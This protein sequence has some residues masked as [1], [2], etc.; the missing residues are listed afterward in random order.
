V[1]RE[2]GILLVAHGNLAESF[3]MSMEMLMGPIQGLETAALMLGEGREQLLETMLQKLEALAGYESVL[4]VADLVGWTPSNTAAEL[5]AGR[6]DLQLIA[7]ANLALLCEIAGGSVLN[8]EVIDA[9]L[10]LSGKTIQNIGA[11]VRDLPRYQHTTPQDDF[12]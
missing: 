1:R 7:G 5:V 3:R 6:T 4:I 8:D 10:S 11:K 2:F 9:W 12:L